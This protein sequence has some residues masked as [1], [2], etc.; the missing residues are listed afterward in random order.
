MKELILISKLILLVSGH[1]VQ[2]YDQGVA[3]YYREGLMQDVC[4]HRV[5]QGWNPH[6]DC[7][8]KC[9]VASIEPDYIGEVWLVSILDSSFHLCQVVDCGMEA[10]LDQLRD[11]NE[12]IE[13]PYW[14]AME[15]EANTYIEGV[16]IWRLGRRETVLFN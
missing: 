2:G 9:L 10:H 11:R 6:L 16:R 14:L 8:Q 7:S 12:I 3:A 4:D 5:S 13:L 1:R 15:A